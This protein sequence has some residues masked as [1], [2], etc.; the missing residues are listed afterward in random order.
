SHDPAVISQAQDEL[1]RAEQIR[2][3]VEP[4]LTPSQQQALEQINSEEKQ[5]F[6]DGVSSNSSS[7]VNVRGAFA[8]AKMMDAGTKSKALDTSILGLPSASPFPILNLPFGKI[9]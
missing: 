7:F 5:A 6:L 1:Q 9:S 2:K 3:Q 8:V 4:D